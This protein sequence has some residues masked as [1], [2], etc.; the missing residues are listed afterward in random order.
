MLDSLTDLELFS[1]RRKTRLA[2]PGH[3]DDGSTKGS[4]IMSTTTMTRRPAPLPLSLSEP[5]VPVNRFP[6]PPPVP[7]PPFSF[8]LAESNVSQLAMLDN[9]HFSLISE[10]DQSP[11]SS[12]SSS[13]KS[14]IVELE[15]EEATVTPKKHARADSRIIVPAITLSESIPG[16]VI[17][18]CRHCAYQTAC[19]LHLHS[20]TSSPGSLSYPQ[21]V[22]DRQS[23]LA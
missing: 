19:P 11:T 22:F 10:N 23:I 5:A 13:R 17:Q 9:K 6:S 2:D 8:P 12:A 15:G 18:T 3:D 4:T 16:S 1:I 7:M 20:S 21:V 14:S